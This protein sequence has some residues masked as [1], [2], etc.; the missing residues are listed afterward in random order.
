LTAF[1]GV[2]GERITVVPL[3]V[4]PCFTPTPDARDEAVKE[5]MQL[6]ARFLLYVGT[7]EPRKNLPRLIKAYDRVAGDIGHDL[8]IAGRDGWKSAPIHAAIAAATH[9]ERI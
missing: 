4:D 2:P 5:R 3:G 1:L 6:P 7:L 8:V 9:R